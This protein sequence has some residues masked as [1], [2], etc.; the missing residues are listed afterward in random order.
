MTHRNRSKWMRDE[1][2]PE[3]RLAREAHGVMG[4]REYLAKRITAVHA[5]AVANGWTVETLERAIA[6]IEALAY[7]IWQEDEKAPPVIFVNRDRKRT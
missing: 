4:R 1:P 2:D 6:D 3:R 5:Q 7:E